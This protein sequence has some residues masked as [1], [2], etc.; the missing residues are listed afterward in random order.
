MYC[1]EC[2][3]ELRDGAAYCPEC[4]APV[5]SDDGPGATGEGRAGPDGERGGEDEPPDEA[6][7]GS[8]PWDPRDGESGVGADGNGRTDTRRARLPYP[9]TTPPLVRGAVVG[10]VVYGLGY[11]CVAGLL[12]AVRTLD[13]R[14]ALAS[15]PVHSPDLPGAGWLF[16]NAHNVAV[17]RRSGGGST[18]T[19]LLDATDASLPP[20]VLYLLPPLLLGL[21][22][23]AF[24]WWILSKRRDQRGWVTP[25]DGAVVG[26]TLTTGYATATAATTATVFTVAPAAATAGPGFLPA[27]GLM[28]IA[29]PLAFGT[30]GGAL[31]GAA[32]GL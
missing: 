20:G 21:A 8:L 12:V 2:G 14:S 26:A 29:Y 19:N 27:V 3:T 28:G 22:G 18:P 11:L 9:E 25:K 17:V 13:P 10:G 15:I 31:A 24:G 6:D 4:G 16:A 7:G 32:M 5:G 23:A 30:L 1:R